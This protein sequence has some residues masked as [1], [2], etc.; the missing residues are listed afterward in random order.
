MK[1]PLK[2]IAI[3]VIASLTGIF[4]Y[5]AYW[6]VD[7]YN[8]TKARNQVAIQNAIRNADYIELFIRVDSISDATNK[9]GELSSNA[10]SNGKISF[11][12][13]FDRGKGKKEERNKIKK[14]FHSND[15]LIVD[16]EAEFDPKDIGLPEGF[17]MYDGYVALEALAFQL[18]SGLHSVIDTGKPI[19]IFRFDSILN[20][21]LKKSGL[22]IGHYTRVVKLK[23]DSTITSSP[24][25]NIDTTKVQRYEHIYDA[26]RKYAFQVYTEDTNRIILAQMAGIL[27]TSLIILIVL[28][29]AFWFLIR[30]I[31]KQKTLDEMKS[32]FTNNVTHELK[33]PI[34]VAYAANDALLNFN[35]AKDEKQRDKYLRISQEQLQKLSGLVEQILSMSAERRRTFK[36]KPEEVDV[37]ALIT[38]LIEQHKLKSEK[39][40]HF[41]IETDRQPISIKVDRAHFSNIISNLIDNAIKYS[42]EEPQITISSHTKEGKLEICVSDRGIGIPAEKQKY[43]FDKFYR[44]PTGN[45]HNVKGYGLGLY[46]VKTMVEKMGGQIE[47]KSE[48]GKGSRFL[49]TI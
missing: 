25:S 29:G 31:I 6:L 46:Y 41:N 42:T 45:L 47:V 19:N 24:E 27:T 15:S 39:P 43:I 35:M 7:M 18:Q 40:A 11:S 1:I 23:N 12:A 30:T 37:N 28:G 20:S 22:D 32:D 48:P 2:Y 38:S 17:D 34:A 33:T 10:D 14:E 3:L 26:Q 16:E 5:Q 13:T 21:E 9:E 49:F 44:V 36:L 4:A 8:T